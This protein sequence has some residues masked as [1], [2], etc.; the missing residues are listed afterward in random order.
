LKMKV[1]HS[2]VPHLNAKWEFAV[3]PPPPPSVILCPLLSYTALHLLGMGRDAVLV[4]LSGGLKDAE[5]RLKGP[6]EVLKHLAAMS[7][8]DNVLSGS[9][10]YAFPLV[11]AAAGI[12][13]PLCLLTASLLLLF[14]RPLLLKLAS[15]VR[16][17]GSYEPQF[18][19]KMLS[20]VGAAATLL[21]AVA[22]STVSAATA[23][24]YLSAEIHAMPISASMLTVPI[25]HCAWQ[26]ASETAAVFV[27]H[28]RPLSRFFTSINGTP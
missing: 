15:T 20:L 7:V 13:S 28:A 10:F 2:R 8:S 19:E 9:V 27:F 14:F 23:S 6:H 24:A 1:S 12:Y 4:Y 5:T 11:A 18:S 21:D 16:I 22:T 25:P 26:S 3:I 17:N